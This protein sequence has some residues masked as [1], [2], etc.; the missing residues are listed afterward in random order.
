MRIG[1]ASTRRAIDTWKGRAK[2]HVKRTQ[3]WTLEFLTRVLTSRSREKTVLVPLLI[4]ALSVRFA[5]LELVILVLVGFY[6][7]KLQLYRF[8]NATAGLF[9]PA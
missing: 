6:F 5:V 4:M 3:L 1:T 2:A 7:V 8:V 9:R